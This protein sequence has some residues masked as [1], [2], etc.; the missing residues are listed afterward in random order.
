M[1]QELKQKTWVDEAGREVPT[2]YLNPSDKLKERHAHTLV[3]RAESL[4]ERLVEYKNLCRRLN[5]EVFAQSM[6]EYRAKGEGKGNYTWYNFDRSVKFEVSVNERIEFDD[7]CIKA[8]K[9]KLDE[10]LSANVTSKQEMIKQIVTD[11]FST[12]RGKLDAKKV[13]S[14]LR[15]KDKVDDSLFTESMELLERSIRRPDSKT[16]FR[17]SKRQEDGSYQ[18]I[19][20]NFSS[21]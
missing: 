21:I 6:E 15:Y 12:T 11:A 8:C 16:Y 3:T 2:V 14:L 17:I 13:M 20:L 5:D 1:K 10:F 9:E 7:L 19:D 4:Y 18:V